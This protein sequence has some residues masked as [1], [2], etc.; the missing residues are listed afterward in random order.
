[1]KR[2]LLLGMIIFATF[3]NAE[4]D[5]DWEYFFGGIN[6]EVGATILPLENGEFITVGYT[7]SFGNGI[8]GK[9]DMYALKFDAQGSTIWEQT[10][11][12]ADS[13]EKAYSITEISDGFIIVGERNEDVVY[14]N[15]WGAIVLKIDFDGNEIWSYKYGGDDNDMLRDIHET[16]DG[17]FISCGVTRSY[18]AQFI[19]G[20]IVKLDADGNIEWQ[21]HYGGSGYE[22]LKQVYEIE[23]GYIAGGYSN[24][25]SFGS[26]D[27]WFIKV[28]FQGEIMWEERIGD[29]GSN[30]MNCFKPTNDGNFILTGE[31]ENG[32]EEMEMFAIKMDSQANV[33]WQQTYD[34]IGQGEG[35]GISQT[36]DGGYFIAGSDLNAT[37]GP[38]QTNGW[39]VKIDADGNFLW[40][41]YV[42][43]TGAGDTFQDAVEISPGIYYIVGGSSLGGNGMLDLWISKIVSDE[44]ETGFVAGVVS[45]SETLLFL[46]GVNISNGYSNTTTD[47]NGS[48]QLEAVAGENTINFSLEGYENYSEIVQVTAN[49]TTNL[50]VLMIEISPEFLPPSNFALEHTYHNEGNFY[51]LSWELPENATRSIS[52]FNIYI[53]YEQYLTV[54]ENVFEY[55]LTGNDVNETMED[56]YVYFYITALYENPDGES[57]PSEILQSEIYVNNSDEINFVEKNKFLI[58]PNPFN[59]TAKIFYTLNESTDIE[60]SVFN[61]KGQFILTL[62]KGV[63]QK[64]NHSV[65]WNGNN[66]NG[67]KA[68]SGVYYFKIRRGKELITKRAILLK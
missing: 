64:G 14:G 51:N 55:L 39:A 52:G 63:R 47:I 37:G 6:N 56:G 18:G 57:E 19:D 58:Y 32:S 34:A 50:D 30:R 42:D 31:T 26:Y 16:E 27:I 13:L 54:E 17:G 3:L 12:V 49:E 40:D 23:D 67:E 59:P 2:I 4:V 36:F 9:P 33:I 53:N 1:M 43:G 21:N 29:T 48:Y 7:E 24:S 28:D 10:Y 66:S 11:G 38:A 15:G 44:I 46:E 41:Y 45:D 22:V 8:W 25:D 35:F 65:I 62:D 61:S 60:I 68:S 5:L 20:W